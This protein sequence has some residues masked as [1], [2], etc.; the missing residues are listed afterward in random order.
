MGTGTFA[1]IITGD[2]PFPSAIGVYPIIAWR[3]N[4]RIV[5]AAEVSDLF[6]GATV[7][8]GVT[9]GFYRSKGRIVYLTIHRQLS[10]PFSYPQLAN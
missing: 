1:S 3:R 2:E 4:N 5:Y 6:A 8:Y 10:C 9:A 7:D